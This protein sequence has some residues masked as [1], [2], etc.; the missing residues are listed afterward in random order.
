MGRYCNESCDD[1]GRPTLLVM[2][3]I[4]EENDMNVVFNKLGEG[5]YSAFS[6]VEVYDQ[7]K[8]YSPDHEEHWKAAGDFYG[9]TVGEIVGWKKGGKS[10]TMKVGGPGWGFKGY[11]N[12]PVDS[13]LIKR[14]FTVFYDK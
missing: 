6:I 11:A 7:M 12:V 14:T 2:L 5:R 13:P 3:N 1:G 10:V 9:V 4:T 8:Y